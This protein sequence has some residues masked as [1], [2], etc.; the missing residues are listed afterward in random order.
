MSTERVTV[1][2]PEDLR[3][4]AAGLA[5]ERGVSFSAVVAEALE[6]WMRSRL[7]DAWL[8]EHQSEQGPFDEADLRA[9]AAEAGVPYL[10]PGRRAERAG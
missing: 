10:P 6:G 4:A 8:V 3:R 1:S 2:L 5:D 9:L 7:V